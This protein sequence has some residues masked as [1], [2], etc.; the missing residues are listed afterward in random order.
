M[1]ASADSEATTRPLAAHTP[2]NARLTNPPLNYPVRT[3]IS[4]A[5]QKVGMFRNAKEC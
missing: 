4:A 2:L 5:A 3:L 1:A